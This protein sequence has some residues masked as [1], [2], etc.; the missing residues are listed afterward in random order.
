M[1]HRSSLDLLQIQS[2][3]F[4]MLSKIASPLHNSFSFPIIQLVYTKNNPLTLLPSPPSFAASTL[5][6]SKYSND[7][8]CISNAD[9]AR[10]H[11]DFKIQIRVAIIFNIKKGLIYL[12]SVFNG[13]RQKPM[14]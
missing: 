2:L 11:A 10:F 9:G 3:G 6:N 7:S 1:L 4:S 14:N 8:L 12:S 5:V 13:L